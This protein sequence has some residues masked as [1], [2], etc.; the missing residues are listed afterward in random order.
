MRPQFTI[1]DAQDSA[2]VMLI[3]KEFTLSKF[4]NVFCDRKFYIR[5]EDDLFRFRKYENS[6]F[7]DT[8]EFDDCIN[9]DYILGIIKNLNALYDGLHKFILSKCECDVAIDN[10]IN[11]EFKKWDNE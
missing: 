10:A 6:M 3:N 1:V 9:V 4:Y 7:F 11:F 5:Y 8:K 2:L